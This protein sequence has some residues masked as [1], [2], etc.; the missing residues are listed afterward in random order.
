M[1]V[2]DHSRVKQY[3]LE[4]PTKDFAAAR[5]IPLAM[6]VCFCRHCFER[7]ITLTHSLNS[8]WFTSVMLIAHYL[9]EQINMKQ[10]ASV[11]M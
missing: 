3:C 2:Q 5:H 8:Y 6:A 4:R 9:G 10:T 1:H 7:L 11:M